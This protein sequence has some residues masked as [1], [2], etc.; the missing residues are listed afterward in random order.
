MVESASWVRSAVVRRGRRLEYFTVVWNLLEGLVALIAGALAGSI[1]L[2]GFGID[3]FI[4]VTSGSVLLWRMSVDAEVHRRERNERRAL[5]A[6]GVCFL[7]LSAYIAYESGTD[8]LSRRQP[9]HSTPGIVLAAVSL[10]VMPLL[11]R[12]K[13]RVGSALGSA[14]MHADAKQTEFC[15]YLSAILLGGL[16]LNALFG[17]WWADPVAALVMVPIIVKE[18]IEGLQSE[19]CNDCR[20]K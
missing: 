1:S 20:E 19:A 8:L 10:I 11:S 18:G 3:S 16:L 5:K 17:L 15:T 4:E 6:V 12:A 2:V 14:A 13:R 7:A 9:E